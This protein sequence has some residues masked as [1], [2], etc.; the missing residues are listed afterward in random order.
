[1]ARQ[2]ALYEVSNAASGEVLS[3][4]STRQAAVNAWRTKA[5]GLPI[6][7]HRLGVTAGK[8]LVVEGT[9]HEAARP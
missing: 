5:T 4:H 7:I 6:E 8:T 3:R 2:N 1:M 9:W